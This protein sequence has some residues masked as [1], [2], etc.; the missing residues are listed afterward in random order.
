MPSNR[1]YP[2]ALVQI[3]ATV[4]NTNYLQILFEY[5]T[6]YNE[7][8]DNY[9]TRIQLVKT[10]PVNNINFTGM[11]DLVSGI[12]EYFEIA[13]GSCSLSMSNGE[14]VWYG[15]G[16]NLVNPSYFQGVIVTALGF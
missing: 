6:N 8:E 12:N 7:N 3:T 2:K 5:V 13:S 15:G 14:Y 1:V 16:E 11:Y 10:L 9:D 4:I